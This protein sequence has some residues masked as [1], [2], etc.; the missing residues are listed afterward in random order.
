MTALLGTAPEPAALLAHARRLAGR[1]GA[2]VPEG[3]RELADL[4]LS[5]AAEIL[6][7]SRQASA[8]HGGSIVMSS[9]GTTGRP[10]LTFMAYHQAFARLSAQWRPLRPGGTLLNLFNPGRLWGSHYYMQAFAQH[11]GCAAAPMGPFEPGEVASWLAT[12]EDMGADA[13]AGTPS[14]LA[15][16]ARGVLD[17][18]RRLQLSS[19]V[20]M[21]EPWTEA[22][23]AVV[24]E[25]FPGIGFW[26]N[27]GSSETHIVAT[28]A[29]ACEVGVLHLLPDQLV[30]LDEEGAL[31]TRVG[32]GWT[33]P[34]VRYRLGD[35]LAAAEC[36][37]GRPDGLRVLGRA[38]DS[39][40]FHG[41]LLGIG[42][43]LDAVRRLP[44]VDEAQL[45]L[46]GENSG[47]R[48]VTALTARYAG[49]AP[50]DVVRQALIAEFEE[51][52][53][54]ALQQPDAVRVERAARLERVERTGKVPPALWR[55]A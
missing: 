6:A 51:L 23:L 34:V 40:K 36:R 54:V 7:V 33:I 25:A 14:V 53:D 8:E 30:E 24:R 1:G 41:S 17:N 45:L 20:W 46:T 27:Y 29:P 38:D 15:D 4:P 28:S 5:G 35:R 18:G 2:P 44:G 16:F 49:D 3:A 39:V 52:R 10:K 32:G 55:A 9:G 43:M 12:C 47:L 50:S 48:T 13:V 22:K 37:C 31:L 42:A 26:G 19:L 11:S 21:A